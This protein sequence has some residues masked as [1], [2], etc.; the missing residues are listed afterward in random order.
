[1]RL[2]RSFILIAAIT[3]AAFCQGNVSNYKNFRGIVDYL[4]DVAKGRIEGEFIINKFGHNPA[5]ATTGEDVWAGGGTYAFYPDTAN[6]MELVCDSSADSIGGAGALSVVIYG[7][8]SNWNEIADTV[9]TTGSA[10]VA[11]SNKYIRMYR[12]IA[13]TAGSDEVNS[14]GISIWA[15]SDSTVGAYIAAEDGQTQQA[16]YTIPAGKEGYFLKGYVAMR[17]DD[18]NG[19]DAAFKW[20]ARLNNGVNGAW[21]TKGQIALIN[22]GSSW[23]QYEYGAPAGPL[24]EKTDIKIECFNAS[25]T[26]GAVGGFDLLIVD[27]D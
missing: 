18:K 3:G 24:P 15:V 13:L 4:I 12:A 19:E 9:N 20:K 27:A 1:M 11:L 16:I 26:V 8:D 14:G 21:A 25:A 10:A 2:I 7:L 22:I 17:N 6:S 5:V 23:W